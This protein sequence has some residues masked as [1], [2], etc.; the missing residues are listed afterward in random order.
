MVVDDNTF[1]EYLIKVV[2]RILLVCPAVFSGNGGIKRKIGKP[3]KRKGK[4]M[5]VI[6]VS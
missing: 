3:K 5:S 2:S 4:I 6:F 1:P